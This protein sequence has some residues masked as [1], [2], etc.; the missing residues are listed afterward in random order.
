MPT[1]IDFEFYV[2]AFLLGGLVG[3]SELL[4]RHPWRLTEIVA[5]SAGWLY[6][7]LNASV[8]VVA[9]RAAIDWDLLESVRAKGEI[10]RVLIVS[11]VAMAAIRSAFANIRVNGKD[12]AAGLALFLETFLVRT[13]EALNHKLARKR[14]T[15]VTTAV[16]GTNLCRHQG[17]FLYNERGVA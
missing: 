4:A 8:S 15:S 13:E 2:L 9:Y 6:L 16:Q 5:S 17:L 14:W 10:W 11:I 1:L 7:F 3:L 12:V